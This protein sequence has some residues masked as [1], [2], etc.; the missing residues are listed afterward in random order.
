MKLNTVKS[1]YNERRDGHR[2]DCGGT[3]IV[4]FELTIIKILNGLRWGGGYPNK[5]FKL[6]RQNYKNCKN[7]QNF[8]KRKK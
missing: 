6:G 4:N 7:R 5:N 8:V 2:G 3:P 1:R